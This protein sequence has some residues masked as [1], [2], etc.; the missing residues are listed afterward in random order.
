[1]KRPG[2]SILRV[3]K[4]QGKCPDCGK[5]RYLTRKDARNARKTL[6]PEDPT[7]GT[8]PCGG[9]WHYGHPM[10]V[11]KRETDH[12]ALPRSAIAGLAAVARATMRETES[13]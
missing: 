8:Y 1:M 9:F 6:H 3:V 13:A 4:A 5:N 10:P 12:D 7:M 2:K 11:F